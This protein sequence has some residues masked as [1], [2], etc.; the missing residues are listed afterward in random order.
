MKVHRLRLHCRMSWT[1]SRMKHRWKKKV[2]MKKTQHLRKSLRKSMRSMTDWQVISVPGHRQKMPLPSW[3]KRSDTAAVIRFLIPFL[4]TAGRNWSWKTDCRQIRENWISTVPQ[5]RLMVWNWMRTITA[6]LSQSR[7][8]SR[9]LRSIRKETYSGTV[10]RLRRS[11][12]KYRRSTWKK[13]VSALLAW[14]W[15]SMQMTILIKTTKKE[16]SFRW[17][18][19]CRRAWMTRAITISGK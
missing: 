17:R 8:R 12:R 15:N 16:P 7:V 19:D 9:W 2:L 5:I 14:D 6:C 13:K 18:R 4:M 1:W 11:T 10:L 3:Q